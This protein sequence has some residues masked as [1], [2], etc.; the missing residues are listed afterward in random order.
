MNPWIIAVSVLG[1]GYVIHEHNKKP[2]FQATDGVGVDGTPVKIAT[3]VPEEITFAQAT[4][5]PDRP[6]TQGPYY[7]VPTTIPGYGVIYA[8]P[9]TV[10]HREGRVFQPAPIIVT[11]NG[12]ASVAVGSVV[13]I[14]HALNALGY[15][16]PPLMINGTLDSRTVGAIKAFQ[17]KNGLVANG[18]ASDATKAALSA[19]LTHMAGGSSMTG[20]IIKRSKPETGAVISHTGTP[21]DTKAAL[22]LAPKQMQHILNT[23]GASP[24]LVEDGKVGKKTVAAIKSF[25]TAH[26]LV[27]DGVSGTK[28]KTA[29]YLASSAGPIVMP[30]MKITA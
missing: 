3:P 22:N 13:N 27:P 9:A 8:P 12:A 7:P 24:P 25:Q 10:I 19:A 26:G 14:Q 20:A 2:E 17:A 29:M 4:G 11:N 1:V 6:P 23:M 21:I 28:T 15:A 30:E 18:N 16:K 5:I